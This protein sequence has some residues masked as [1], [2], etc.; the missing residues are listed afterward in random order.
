[1]DPKERKKEM[2]LLK[3]EIHIFFYQ[4]TNAK[5]DSRDIMKLLRKDKGNIVLKEF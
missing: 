1:M 2:V 3:R 4:E 5:I